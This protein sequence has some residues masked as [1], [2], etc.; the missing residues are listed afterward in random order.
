MNTIVAFF[1]QQIGKALGSTRPVMIL[2]LHYPTSYRA[3]I[4]IQRRRTIS[5][6]QQELGCFFAF[7]PRLFPHQHL[8]QIQHTT[9]R[10][11][12]TI[13]SNET[14]A[15]V[16]PNSVLVIQSSSSLVTLPP[17][18]QDPCQR[19]L[20]CSYYVVHWAPSEDYRLS[21]TAPTKGRK[22]LDSQTYVRLKLLSPPPNYN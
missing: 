4:T 12:S 10:P 8:W 18:K 5:H 17:G 15:S 22:A 20:L 3:P 1:S 9:P 6:E 13:H 21:K 16:Q 14:I 19:R 11:W 2:T 7:Q